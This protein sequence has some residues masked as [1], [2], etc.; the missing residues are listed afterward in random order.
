MI[1]ENDCLQK[2]GVPELESNMTLLIVPKLYQFCGKIPKRIYCN[3]DLKGKLIDA[4]QNIQER[5]LCHLLESWD[6][7][8]NIR[9][10]KGNYNK[11]SLHSWGIA[12]DINSKTNGYNKI[13]QMDLN[14]V[15]C[16]IDAGFD[17][18]GFWK[19]K[20]GMHFQLNEI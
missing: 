20:D 8:F 2:Y 19:I 6:G 15:Q 3:K 16:F 11:Y 17:W 14:L 12:I 7:C 1:I 4:L 13:P 9:K 10:S 5:G 18:G